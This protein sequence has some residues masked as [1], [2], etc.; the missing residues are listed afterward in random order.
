M[1][2]KTRRSRKKKK[3]DEKIPV[4]FIAVLVGLIVALL[5]FAIMVSF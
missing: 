1:K 2:P 3:E 4:A 5:I